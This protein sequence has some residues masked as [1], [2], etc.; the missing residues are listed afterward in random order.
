MVKLGEIVDRTLLQEMLDEGF[1]VAK[2]HPTEGLLIFNYTPKTQYSWTWNDVTEQCRGLV[3]HYMTDEVVARPFRKFHNWDAQGVRVPTG[4]ALVMPKFDGSL[5]VLYPTSDGHAIATRGSFVSE[6]AIRGSIMYREVAEIVGFEPQSGRTYLF[7]II[8]PQ[9][10]IVVDYGEEE[11]LV[12]LDVIDTETGRSDL[13]A[14]DDAM[15]P[16]KAQRRLISEFTHELIYEIPDGDEGFVVYWPHHD[17]RVKMKAAE[18]VRLHRILTNVSSKTIWEALANSTGVEVILE[19]VPDEFYAWV[20][21]TVDELQAQYRLIE[22]DATAACVY[23]EFNAAAERD[24]REFK[25]VFAAKLKDHPYKD[26]AFKMRDGKDYR[27]AIWK[28]IKPEYSRPFTNQSEDV[29]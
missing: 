3:V 8:Y 10:R 9:N 13:Q 14:F 18:Y 7:E 15:W 11:M 21:K 19:N 26:V 17:L 2:E 25:K 16:D 1:V 24:P 27:A 4:H 23:A 12:L 20:R 29:A 5:G 22:M 6:Q 28:R